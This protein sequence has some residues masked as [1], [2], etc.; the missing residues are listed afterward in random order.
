MALTVVGAGGFGAARAVR[1][2]VWVVVGG[3][4]VFAVDGGSSVVAA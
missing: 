1:G 3:S 4:G 2:G